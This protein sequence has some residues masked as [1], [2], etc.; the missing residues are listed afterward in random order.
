MNLRTVQVKDF[1]LKLFLVFAIICPIFLYSGKNYGTSSMRIGQEQFFQLGATV[2]FCVAMLENI[3]LAVF[4]LWSVFLYALFQFPDVGGNYVLNIFFGCVLYQI[5]YVLFDEEKAHF[6]FKSLLW[7]AALNVVYIAFQFFKIDF[8]FKS[9]TFDE[10]NFDPV[11]FMGLKAFMGMFFALCI[12]LAA[13]YNRLASYLCLV[14]VYISESSAA[15]CGAAV[16]ILWDLWNTSKRLFCA[17]LVVCLLGCAAFIWKDSGANMITDRISVWK[18]CLN[19]AVKHPI[20]GQGLDSFRNTS[21]SKPYLYFMR[22]KDNGCLRLVYDKPTKRFIIP[23][24]LFTKEEKEKNDKGISVV[25]PWDH[26]HNEYV[27][28]FYEFGVLGLVLLVMLGL[29]VRRRYKVCHYSTNLLP[30]IGFFLVIL[31]TSLT[32]FPLHVARIGYLVPIMLGIYYKITD[33]KMESLEKW[34]DLNAI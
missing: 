14:P 1:G 3:Y 21:E 7:L 10:Q 23:P 31:V 18:A 8:I 19:D 6:F 4:C 33:Q 20:I 30:F 9:A 29:D 13:Q 16:A 12:P 24:N 2:L 27:S 11:G 5:S 15:V 26:P 34:R 28:V 22:N 25:N 32:Q 17:G